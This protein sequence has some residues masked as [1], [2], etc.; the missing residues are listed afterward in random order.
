MMR[1]G[2]TENG[3]LFSIPKYVAILKWQGMYENGTHP[4][5]II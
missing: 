1:M 2:P 4:H 5:Q 3:G